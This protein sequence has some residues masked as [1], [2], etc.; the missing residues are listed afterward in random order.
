LDLTWISVE[1]G[2][3][4]I[5]NEWISICENATSAARSMG[6]KQKSAGVQMTEASARARIDRVVVS[7]GKIEAVSHPAVELERELVRKHI[8]SSIERRMS[9]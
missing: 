6:G 1:R 9:V 2:D 7:L 4:S 8:Y 3:A 5:Q